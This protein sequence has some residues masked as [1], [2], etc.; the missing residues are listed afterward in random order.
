M[1]DDT[2]TA[3]RVAAYLAAAQERWGT[4][5][6]MTWHDYATALELLGKALR[7][8]ADVPRLI[9][10]VEAALE[11]AGQWRAKAFALMEQLAAEDA[12]GTSAALKGVGSS[13]QD[14]CA[15]DLRAAITTA[16]LGEVP[17]QT[18]PTQ[19]VCI[20]VRFSDTGGY[21]I[22]DLCCPVHGVSGTE[23]LDGPW[24]VLDGG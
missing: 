22:G 5:D 21:R 20:C 11:L 19:P 14:T 15:R 4:A 10:A 18:P 6:G 13:V 24:G 23:P 1:P 2:A 16:L 7:S 12:Q 17:E 3:D 8:L 9:A